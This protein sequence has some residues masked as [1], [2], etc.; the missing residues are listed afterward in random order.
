MIYLDLAELPALAQRP[1]MFATSKHA[2]RSFL[3]G[4]HLF[5]PQ[6]SLTEELRSLVFQQ[7]RQRPRG[8][9]RLLTQLRHF[10][11]YL[12]PLNMYYLFD[13]DDTQVQHVVAEV[14]NTPWNER[15][16]YVLSEETRTA[17]NS[18]TIDS[19][20]ADSNSMQHAHAK[21]FHVSPFL[22]MNM[23]YRWQL[24]QPGEQLTVQ[25]ANYRDDN[26]LFT[27]AMALQR[28]ELTPKQLRRMTFRY[29]LM[30]AQI[31]AGIYYQALKLWWKQCPFY[32]HPKKN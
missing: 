23:Q 22:D 25:V 16:C 18:S 17:D 27:A 28:R 12:S 14:N 6:Q 11:Y 15:H 20:S 2:S 24:S 31:A 7:T 10:G 3:R 13:E 21:G 19:N 26:R 29:P 30:T 1:D 9:I 5:N 4:D 8:P 32:T